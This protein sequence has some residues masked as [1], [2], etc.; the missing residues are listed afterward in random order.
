M[1]P[2]CYG[3]S[4]QWALQHLASLL[5]AH[6]GNL[7]QLYIDIEHRECIGK[8]DGDVLLDIP[9]GIICLVNR[10]KKGKLSTIGCS[11]M[12]SPGKRGGLCPAHDTFCNQPTDLCG[13]RP[14]LPQVSANWH[15]CNH[16]LQSVINQEINRV[17]GSTCSKGE[18]FQGLQRLPVPA[19][20]KKLH[21][22]GGNPACHSFL[23]QS[24]QCQGWT[25]P[26]TLRSVRH[27]VVE[28]VHPTLAV[29]TNNLHQALFTSTRTHTTSCSSVW[30]PS[31][32]FV[33][34]TV[35]FKPV[36]VVF[37]WRL[38]PLEPPLPGRP[39]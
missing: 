8:K 16:L 27:S 22:W 28:L 32:N 38:K 1:R 34:F 24:N 17:V 7:L 6:M 14:K 39:Q 37:F 13:I 23:F 10:S 5:C 19:V 33:V 30:A 4:P 29:G 12:S 15:S 11:N 9:L 3:A 35:K 2:P 25:T 26:T 31:G 20:S 18:T 21:G 36:L